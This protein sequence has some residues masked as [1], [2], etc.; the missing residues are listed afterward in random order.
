MSYRA[1][2]PRRGPPCQLAGAIA[3]ARLISTESPT[4]SAATLARRAVRAGGDGEG[5][6]TRLDEADGARPAR[7]RFQA[8]SARAREE[9]EHDGVGQPRC[10][11]RKEG[12][13]H[14]VEHRPGGTTGRCS[15]PPAAVEPGDDPH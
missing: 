9:V 7:E 14:A 8:E 11:R 6:G 2:V 12:F 15:N 5:G 1:S 3:S 4:S 13:A 10:E